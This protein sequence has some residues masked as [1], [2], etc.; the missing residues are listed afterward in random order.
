MSSEKLEAPVI[1]DS[2]CSMHN[3]PAY[4]NGPCDCSVS[5]PAATSNEAAGSLCPIDLAHPMGEKRRVVIASDEMIDGERVLCIAIKDPPAPTG[6]AVQP[7]AAVVGGLSE[8][9]A[10]WNTKYQS[11][12]LM[13]RMSPQLGGM[14]GIKSSPAYKA[15]E[16]VPLYAAA[17]RVTHAD[18]QDGWYSAANWLR[19]NYQDYA[20]IASL[21]EAMEHAAP[22]AATPTLLGRRGSDFQTMKACV[23]ALENEQHAML[24]EE[25]DAIIAA[26]K[27]A[28]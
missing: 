5:R 21:C 9:V 3:M 18:E 7:D 10:W 26:L 16:L 2:D 6:E 22:D 19:N 23:R 8:P 25:L 14:V 17:G 12:M 24:A 27:E 15:G 11:V 13:T 20:N 1:H 28:P 4:P